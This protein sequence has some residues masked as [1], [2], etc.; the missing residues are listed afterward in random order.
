MPITISKVA[1]EAQMFTGIGI[2]LGGGNSLDMSCYIESFTHLFSQMGVPVFGFQGSYSGI[3]NAFT[4]EG[5][6]DQN[7]VTILTPEMV[8]GASRR[9]VP[10]LRTDRSNCVKFGTEGVDMR[11]HIISNLKRLGISHFIDIGGDG[12]SGG[13]FDLISTMKEVLEEKERLNI[14]FVV[15]TVDGLKGADTTPGLECGAIHAG[16]QILYASNDG[17]T[18]SRT[19]FQVIMGRNLGDLVVKGS[20]EAV[21]MG[22]NVI[23]TVVPE[24]VSQI[25]FDELFE[26]ITKNPYGVVAIA[27]GVVL[28]YPFGIAQ[29]G[30]GFTQK[31]RHPED[32]IEEVLIEEAEKRRV[33]LNCKVLPYDY[34]PRA[35]EPD[36]RGIEMAKAIAH[37]HFIS[38]LSN[39]TQFAKVIV[40]GQIVS[41]PIE[42]IRNERNLIS[43]M[44]DN[45]ELAK[46]V[47]ELKLLGVMV[48]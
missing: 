33:K 47:N 13:C 6:V 38:L 34:G 32:R 9:A 39:E 35:G 28:R 15:G 1:K 12:S 22:A 3:V 46:R 17:K 5:E 7:N 41:V 8:S 11:K 25:N 27:E 18:N 10:I 42:K 2:K 37:S 21:Q 4:E 36:P 31:I 48:N 16:R 44:G 20:L 29:D 30:G 23:A 14:S 40:N 19:V 43:K 24:M 26:R 45:S